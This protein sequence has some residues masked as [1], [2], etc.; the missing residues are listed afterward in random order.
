[1]ANL[2]EPMRPID[3]ENIPVR[4]VNGAP[5]IGVI[6]SLIAITLTTDRIGFDA[7]G[8]VQSEMVV[9]A[10]LRFDLE[11]ARILRDILNTQIELLTPAPKDKP[12]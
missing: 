1:M 8:K 11:M 10:R 3:P 12:N 2:G 9:A 4:V 7:N 6:G 5:Q